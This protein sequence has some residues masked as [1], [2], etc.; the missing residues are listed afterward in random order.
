MRERRAASSLWYAGIWGCTALPS[1][2]THYKVMDNP[3]VCPN[4]GAYA[5]VKVDVRG[6][7]RMAAADGNGPVNALDKALR[8][9][10][11]NYFPELSR[12]SLSDYKVRVLDTR[13]ATAARVRVVIQSTDGRS[14]WSTLGVSPDV[15]EASLQAL[16]DSIEYKLLSS[17]SETV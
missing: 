11:S 3:T 7:Q 8:E 1:K 9:A 15:I 4:L 10:L 12:V 16:I 2:L 13:D 5:V 14:T 6:E 17:G